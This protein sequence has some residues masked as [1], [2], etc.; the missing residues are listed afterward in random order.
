MCSGGRVQAA[1]KGLYGQLLV[2]K[3]MHDASV[4]EEEK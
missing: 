3:E 1:G 2:K 4:D